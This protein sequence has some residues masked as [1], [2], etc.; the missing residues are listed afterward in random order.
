MGMQNFYDQTHKVELDSSKKL[1]KLWELG[2][3]F[4]KVPILEEEKSIQNIFYLK[5]VFFEYNRDIKEKHLFKKNY[6][7]PLGFFFNM[8]L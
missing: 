2:K 1:K 8:D 3:T 6:F 5:L 4:F 7:L